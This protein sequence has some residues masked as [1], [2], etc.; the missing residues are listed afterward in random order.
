MPRCNYLV[1]SHGHE[2]RGEEGSPECLLQEHHEGEHLVVATSDSFYPNQYVLWALD[3]DCDCGW[4]REDE[5]CEC[6]VYNTISK[7]EAEKLLAEKG[8]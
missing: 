6:F 1:P 4:D 2:L 5:D 8:A 7:E 3:E